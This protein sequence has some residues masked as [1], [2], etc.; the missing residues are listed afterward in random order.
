MRVVLTGA[1][2]FIG[3]HVWRALTDAGARVTTVGRRALPDSDRHACLDV[4][5]ST[6]ADLTALLAAERTPVVLVNCA[7][8][9]GADVAALAAGNVALPATLVAAAARA[10]VP[11]RL[12]HLGSAA[13]YGPVEPGSS[14]REGDPVRPVGCYA[15]SKLAGTRI[16]GAAARFGLDAV[17]LRVTNPVGPGA[18]TDSLSGTLV[19]QI[20]RARDH[21]GP[22]RIGGV[23]AVRDFVDV[24]DVAAAVVAATRAPALVEPVLNVGSGRATT[25]RELVDTM[26]DVSGYRGE[27]RH[28]GGGSARSAAVPWLRADIGAAVRVLGWRPATDLRTTL[29]DLWRHAT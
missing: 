9:T 17:V 11:A 3:R 15:R 21:G 16:V 28:D 29:T 22:V 13:E 14:A 20:R 5:P 8:T 2:G 26:L 4:K 24:R 25:V 27:V 7:G 12:V 19:A 10:G 23:T 6:G 18:P 1:G